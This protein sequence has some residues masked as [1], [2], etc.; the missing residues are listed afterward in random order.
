MAAIG[1]A[2]DRLLLRQVVR[3]KDRLH[4]PNG[5]K[6]SLQPRIASGPLPTQLSQH[7]SRTPQQWR[8]H[9]R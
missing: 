1:F 9:S 5:L 2:D 6:C 4:S 8:V 7:P 3:S